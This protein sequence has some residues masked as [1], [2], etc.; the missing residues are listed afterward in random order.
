M[1]QAANLLFTLGLVAF[2]GGVALVDYRAA[3]VV[4][5][6][7]AMLYAVLLARRLNASAAESPDGDSAP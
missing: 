4:G 1:M 3:M 7:A 5:G 6:A 2:L